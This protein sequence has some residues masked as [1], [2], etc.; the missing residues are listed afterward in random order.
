LGVA[1]QSE[2]GSCPDP[3]IPSIRDWDDSKASIFSI[4]PLWETEAQGAEFVGKVPVLV[5]F[6]SYN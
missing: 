1:S 5:T 3:R 2:R 4:F 6:L